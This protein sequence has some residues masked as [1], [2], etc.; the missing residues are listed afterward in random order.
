MLER[1]WISLIALSLLAT[2]VAL[3]QHLLP[4][5][6]QSVAGVVVLV[7]ALIKAR[8]ILS[9]YLELAEAPDVL[10]SFTVGLSMFLIAASVLYVLA[11]LVQPSPDPGLALVLIG[12]VAE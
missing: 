6:V 12:E 8:I 5:S 3:S 11:I 10:R 2:A 7:L 4:G 1:A 9:D